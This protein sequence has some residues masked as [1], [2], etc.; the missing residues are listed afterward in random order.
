MFLLG[1]K[2]KFEG[3]FGYPLW[4]Y[5]VGYLADLLKIERPKEH[6]KAEDEP[7]NKGDEETEKVVQWLAAQW[8]SVVK[9]LGQIEPNV[10]WANDY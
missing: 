5:E 4:R 3:A 1:I 7:S 8:Q 9:I 6:E 10:Q 2:T